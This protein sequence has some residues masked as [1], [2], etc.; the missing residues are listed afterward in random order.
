MPG[1][2]NVNL[3]HMNGRVYDPSL[4]R[5]LSVDPVFEFPTNMQSLNPYSYVLNNPLSLTD[6]TGY[7]TS[8]CTSGAGFSMGCSG[9]DLHDLQLGQFNSLVSKAE[10][11]AYLYGGAKAGQALTIYLNNKYGNL[12]NN[13]TSKFEGISNSADNA[14][15]GNH[16]KIGGSN[17]A[18]T[19]MGSVQITGEMKPVPARGNRV[20]SC[21]NTFFVIDF[22]H[23]SPP[24]H[25]I[26][27]RVL[28]CDGAW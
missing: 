7:S 15:S 21:I 22:L 18:G 2:A 12:L 1:A 13:G 23:G 8:I 20:R 26:G 27:W 6:P 25:R 28:P 9:Q 5:F 11:G 10:G 17:Q 14:N 24:A 16:T 4:G 3:I 19:A